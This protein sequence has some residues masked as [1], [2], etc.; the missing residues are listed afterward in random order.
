ML[1]RLLGLAGIVAIVAATQPGIVGARDLADPNLSAEQARALFVDAGYAVDQLQ[2]WDWLS[3]PV[4]TFQVRDVVRGR[5]LLV[6]VC[7]DIALAQ[8][9]SSRIVQ[10]YSA[11]TWIDNLALFEANADDWQRART[12]AQA[13]STGM[14]ESESM[15]D[16]TTTT[17]PAVRVEVEYTDLVLEV[18]DGAPAKSATAEPLAAG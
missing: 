4:V 7:P 11:S 9:A 15:S 17:V 6:Q 2:T 12:V 14:N 1:R 13:R 18:L 5:L 3:P 16:V 10:G 8:R